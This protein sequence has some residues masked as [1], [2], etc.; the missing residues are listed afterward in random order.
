MATQIIGLIQ[1]KHERLVLY[2]N[3]MVPDLIDGIAALAQLI[4]GHPE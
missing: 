1:W 4:Y 2:M 3:G